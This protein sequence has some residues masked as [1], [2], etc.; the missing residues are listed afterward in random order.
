MSCIIERSLHFF[1]TAIIYLFI[2][3]IVQPIHLFILSDFIYPSSWSTLPSFMD[4]PHH[5]YFSKCSINCAV[6]KDKFIRVSF[7]PNTFLL[8]SSFQCEV[9]IIRNWW[10]FDF[11]SSKWDFVV[12][13]NKRVLLLN[14]ILILK[15]CLEWIWSLN[16]RIKELWC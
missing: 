5:G 9:L 4:I 11:G 2:S 15:S 14:S 8:F 12:W 7:S 13:C 16:E 3:W 1:L 10:F 6:R